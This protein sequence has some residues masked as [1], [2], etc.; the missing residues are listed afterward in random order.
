MVVALGSWAAAVAWIDWRQRRVPNLAL[1]LLLVPAALAL[2]V[3]RQ[4]LLGEGVLSSLGGCGLAFAA[5]LP[6]YLLKRFGA[7]DV[8]LAGCLG[9]LLGA[10]RTLEMLLLAAVLLGLLAITLLLAGSSRESRFPAAPAFAAAFAV[11]MLWGPWLLL[12]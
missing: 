6:G 2:V 12:T 3:Q 4:G 8:K 7:A 5:T 1:L 9:L 10:V 11:G